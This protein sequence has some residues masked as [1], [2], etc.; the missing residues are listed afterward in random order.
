M[1][2]TGQSAGLGN[3]VSVP[4]FRPA[5]PQE[6]MKQNW[7]SIVVNLQKMRYNV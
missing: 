6:M 4:V 3:A 5:V 1:R 2:L 7:R